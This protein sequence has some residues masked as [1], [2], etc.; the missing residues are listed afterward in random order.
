MTAVPHQ[1]RH[2]GVALRRAPQSTILQGFPDRFGIH[3]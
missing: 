3:E 1:E 2:H